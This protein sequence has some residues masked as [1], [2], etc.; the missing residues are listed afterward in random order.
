MPNLRTISSAVPYQGKMTMLVK[1]HNV[2]DIM[3]AIVTK[4][5]KH[6]SDYDKISEKFW[7]GNAKDTAKGLFNFLKKNVQY[8]IES[9]KKQ[10]VKSPGAITN[11]L[12]GD[13]KHYASFINGVLHSLQRKG[14]PIGGLQYRYAGYDASNDGVHHVFAVM[15]DG[16][17]E[18]WIDPVLSWFNYHKPYIVSQNAKI[19]FMPLYEISGFGNIFDDIKKGVK[20][21]VKK[22][23]TA[24]RVNTANAQSAVRTNAAN[25]QKAVQQA[26]KDVKQGAKNTVKK[27]A[28]VVLKVTGTAP[29]NAFLLLLK[30]NAFNMAH[31]LYDFLHTS[32]AN[33][34][35]L[36]KKWESLGGNYS[37]L[38]SNIETG[39]K[40]YLARHK[41]S[42]AAYNKQ[43]NFINGVNI[44]TPQ[45]AQHLLVFCFCFPYHIPGMTDSKPVQ[46]R[47]GMDPASA[48]AL[49]TAAATVIAIM[50][51]ILQKAKWSA[52]DKAKAEAAAEA[53]AQTLSNGAA[54]TPN[55]GSFFT[56]DVLMPDGSTSGTL[57][58]SVQTNADGTKVVSIDSV[59]E[60]PGTPTGNSLS[61]QIKQGIDSAKNFVL[62]N[63]MPLLFIT[64]GVL[65][66]KSGILTNANK[67]KRRK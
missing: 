2:D 47:V 19:G 28:P 37:S 24:V 10:T 20:N 8:E 62:E 6:F 17:E 35:E 51:N 54:T 34:D 1:N 33:E 39:M 15:K 26:K 23:E 43:N 13:C 44:A 42:P 7:A 4:H 56:G 52:E 67:P 59:T 18:I 16:T 50:S 3:H 65:L 58:A 46:N 32:K 57:E 27:V 36:R 30:A 61:E 40:G 5:N 64:G 41:T 66:W 38:K 9:D 31:R 29:R 60:P 22:V 55:G 12:Y 63:K 11:D 49:M 53:G 14:Y 25:A 21:T 48:A 45:Q